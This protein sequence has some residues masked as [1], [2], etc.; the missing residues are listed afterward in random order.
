MDAIRPP[1]R[2]NMRAVIM[3]AQTPVPWVSADAAHA[4]HARYAMA[5]ATRELYTLYVAPTEINTRATVGPANR[6]GK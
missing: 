2:A 4:E 3:V 6:K 1:S 5:R